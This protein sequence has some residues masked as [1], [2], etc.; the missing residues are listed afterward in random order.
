MSLNRLEDHGGVI[1]QVVLE[2][3]VEGLPDGT[4]N[5]VRCHRP[6]NLDGAVTLVEDHLALYPGSQQQERPEPAPRRRPPLR[7]GP[8]PLP[9]AS[10][11][12]LPR[13]NFS[14][15]YFPSTDPGSVA[16]GSAS[17]RAPQALGPG[18]WRCGQPGHLHRDCL[19]ME[20]GQLVRVVGP[21][22]SAPDPEG[23]YCIP[24]D[25]SDRGLGAVLTQQVDGVDCPVLYISRK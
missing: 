19:I 8:S 16:G 20:V 24:T 12:P 3:F 14:S 13:P 7:A 11:P 17:L 1:E 4:A 6:T 15:A 18:C 21:P 22:T 23:A 10:T 9:R 2:Q 25:A 5:W